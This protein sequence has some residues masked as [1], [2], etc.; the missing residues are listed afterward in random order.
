MELTLVAT[1]IGIAQ[2]LKKWGVDTKY[3]VL[4]N[5]AFGIILYSI[6]ADHQDGQ[7][8]IM[9]GIAIGLGASGFY[10]C[11]KIAGGNY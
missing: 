5:L 4:L 11:A 8:M 6:S 3:I 10:E 7:E 1:I 2:I 9:R